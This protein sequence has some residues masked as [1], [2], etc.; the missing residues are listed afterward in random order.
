MA[1]LFCVGENCES[2]KSG[3]VSA[4]T[5]WDSICATEIWAD[6]YGL[7]WSQIGLGRKTVHLPEECRT[8][9]RMSCVTGKEKERGRM[10]RERRVGNESIRDWSVLTESDQKVSRGAKRSLRSRNQF[11]V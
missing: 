6:D 3:G 5:V 11:L 8:E 1:K 2:N 4:S 10:I 7:G 9:E